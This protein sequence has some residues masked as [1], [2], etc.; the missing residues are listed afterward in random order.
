ML[1][2]S[3]TSA[4]LK[5]NSAEDTNWVHFWEKYALLV[6]IILI[7]AVIGFI[8]LKGVTKGRVRMHHANMTGAMRDLSNGASTLRPSWA[9][10]PGE[11]DVFRSGVVNAVRSRG[12]PRSY[13]GPV[14]DNGSPLHEIVMRL[15]ASLEKRGS[16]FAEQQ[17][18]AAD[19][20]ES[21]WKR[22]PAADKVQFVNML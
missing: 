5:I 21:A 13:A 22:L 2:A 12:V 11:V 15:T 19:L 17:I 3:A 9:G 7:G 4:R 1:T 10:K 14:L 6:V 16:S 18:G 8:V 20:V